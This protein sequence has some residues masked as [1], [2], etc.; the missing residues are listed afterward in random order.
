MTVEGVLGSLLV[1]AVSKRRAKVLLDVCKFCL[2]GVAVVTQLFSLPEGGPSKK[3]CGNKV[4]KRIVDFFKSKKMLNLTEAEERKIE[5]KSDVCELRSA[6]TA[7]G[8]PERASTPPLISADSLLDAPTKDFSEF[9]CSKSP[10][11]SPSSSQNPKT[12]RFAALGRKTRKRKGS[13]SLDASRKSSKKFKS[14]GGVQPNVADMFRLKA[15]SAAASIPVSSP[16]VVLTR[17]QKSCSSDFTDGASTC[18]DLISDDDADDVAVVG[19]VPAS[20][21]EPRLIVPPPPLRRSPRESVRQKAALHVEL[22]PS[23]G[24]SKKLRF[25]EGENQ[26]KISDLLKNTKPSRYS[27]LRF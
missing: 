7:S 19:F 20:Q 3:T 21:S 24:S 14:S 17:A 2:F 23:K 6:T 15:A 25:T 18:S 11:S 5:E 9:L 26:P 12:E 22:T 8:E 4:K 10:Q 27:S 1:I 16:S 13:Y